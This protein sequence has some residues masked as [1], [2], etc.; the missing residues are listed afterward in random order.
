MTCDHIFEDD[1][2][3]L[4]QYQFLNFSTILK[5]TAFPYIFSVSVLQYQYNGQNLAVY[6]DTIG[7]N[8]S[9]KMNHRINLDSLVCISGNIMS[10]DSIKFI[11][12]DIIRTDKSLTQNPNE[13]LYYELSVTG[14]IK[15]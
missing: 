12:I 11:L 10:I 6:S 7:I 5:T 2:Y 14:E 1:R 13:Y 4:E 9:L 15:E 3:I 8:D